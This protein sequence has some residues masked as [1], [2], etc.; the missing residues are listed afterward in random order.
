MTTLNRIEASS[1]FLNHSRL[2]C[3]R[4]WFLISLNSSDFALTS[5]ATLIFLILLL[6]GSLCCKNWLKHSLT[7]SLLSLFLSLAFLS[8]FLLIVEKLSAAEET[9]EQSWTDRNK[10]IRG[11]NKC[12]IF[13]SQR[14]APHMHTLLS[15]SLS[16][17]LTLSLFLSK[18]LYNAFL[19]RTHTHKHS[20]SL[21]FK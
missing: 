17:L 16:L 11:W 9:E 20:L 13:L 1:S 19:S 10:K 3:D 12:S 5:L 2:C 15:L 14:H 7:V 4:T 21:D 8:C 18:P 6:F